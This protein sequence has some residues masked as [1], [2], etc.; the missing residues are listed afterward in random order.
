MVC[1]SRFQDLTSLTSPFHFPPKMGKK[2]KRRGGTGGGRKSR[3][4]AGAGGAGGSSSRSFRDQ[5]AAA[6]AAAPQAAGLDTDTPADALGLLETV[7]PLPSLKGIISTNDDPGKCAMCSDPIV[8]SGEQHA[9]TTRSVSMRC[10]GKQFCDECDP[11]EDGDC[12][13]ALDLLGESRCNFCNALESDIASLSLQ[14]A[15]AGTAWAQYAEGLHHLHLEQSPRVASLWIMK[16]AANGHPEAFLRLSELCRG[17]GRDPLD[18]LAA[19]A[20]V[21]KARSL[22]PDLALRSNEILAGVA[23]DFLENGAVEEAMG[24][25]SDI[26][27]EVDPNALDGSLCHRIFESS[28]RI[29]LYQL[30]G[31]M[32]ARS[33]C[34]GA[35]GSAFLASGCYTLSEHYALS[36]LWL[37][38]ACKTKA[39]DRSWASNKQQRDEIRSKL[40][41][42][43]DSCGGCDAALEGDT[44]KWCRGC[45]A[46]CYCSKECQKL[47]W[48]RADGGHRAECKETQ[49]QARKM[50]EATQSGKI[51][52][53]GNKD[54]KVKE[55]QRQLAKMEARVT[56]AEEGSHKRCKKAK[57]MQVC[58]NGGTEAT[59]LA[60]KLAR[61][62]AHCQEENARREKELAHCLEELATERAKSRSLEERSRS[63]EERIYARRSRRR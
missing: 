23:E 57:A 30:A 20:F 44:R 17:E 13:L 19:Q 59:E 35:V 37:S 22:H 6:K 7:P 25:L 18:L 14:K 29:K 40:R 3:Q 16:A 31:D 62:L 10:C 48:N 8:L 60:E 26:A 21:K 55:L 45:K 2:S 15:N 11:C 39:G 41:E 1:R 63:L 12:G 33:F 51:S 5:L 52:I 56:K 49:D 58:A 36:K 47:H 54:E 50:L 38:V 42:I 61:D 28:R 4:A 32:S 53:D 34:H 43:R 27:N 24:I 46:F 9:T